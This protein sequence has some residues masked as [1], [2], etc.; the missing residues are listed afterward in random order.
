MIFDLAFYSIFIF[1]VIG[2]ILGL[3]DEGIVAAFFAAIIGCIPSVVPLIIV[4]A[5]WHNYAGQLSIVAEQNRV[6]AVYEQQRDELRKTMQQFNYPK[7][8]AILNMD[9][10]IAAIVVQLGNTENL[11]A[12]ARATQ[13]E[14]YKEI[15]AIKMGPVSSVVKYVKPLGE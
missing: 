10:P 2:F 3:L 5:V 4:L 11:L 8:S 1:P 12:K 13:A 6:V 7:G 15:A 14:A 9:S